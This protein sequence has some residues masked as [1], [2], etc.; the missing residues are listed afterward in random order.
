ML[1]RIA[2][3]PFPSSFTDV[4]ALLIGTGR[5]AP[6]EAEQAGLG[7]LAARVPLYLG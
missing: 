3:G 4:D 6:T 5:R 2:G 1:E 7:D